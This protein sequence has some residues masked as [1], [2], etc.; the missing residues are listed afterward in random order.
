MIIKKYQNIINH[1]TRWR[2]ENPDSWIGYTIE[3]TDILSAIIVA[4][5]SENEEGKRNSHQRRLKRKAINDFS[6]I[7]IQKVAEI[8]NAK[9]FDNLLQIVESCK[10][11]G[12]GELACYDT[13]NRIGCK[14]GLRPEKVYLHAGTKRGAEKIFGLKINKRFI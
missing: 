4:A 1:Y 14:I 5:K 13:A 11:K 6:E 7:L 8:S 3:Q 10:V 9:N 12:I 2:N